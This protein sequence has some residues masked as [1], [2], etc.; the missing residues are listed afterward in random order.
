MSHILN[1]FGFTCQVPSDRIGVRLSYVRIRDAT[2]EVA[3]VGWRERARRASEA[4]LPID[5]LQELGKTAEATILSL[6][7]KF[8]NWHKLEP[9]HPVRTELLQH[10]R[11][12]V[13]KIAILKRRGVEPVFGCGKLNSGLQPTPMDAA[14]D[15]ATVQVAKHQQPTMTGAGKH[16]PAGTEWFESSADVVRRR[17]IVLKNP[18]MPSKSLCKVFD[19]A[20]PPI[21]LPGGW[22]DKLNVRNW[23]EAY[24]N[25]TGRKRIQKIISTDRRAGRT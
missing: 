11:E 1:C 22:Q 6:K 7:E 20:I 2:R 12:C 23:S 5:V 18:R 15:E 10:E 3:M 4:T 13:E 16:E 9:G 14:P 19:G 25:Q 17:Q 21:P 24:K 8:P